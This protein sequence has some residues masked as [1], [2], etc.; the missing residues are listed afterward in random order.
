MDKLRKAKT[1]S[2]IVEVPWMPSKRR[3]AAL[4]DSKH[5][6]YGRRQCGYVTHFRH[7]YTYRTAAAEIPKKIH[8][9]NVI[10]DDSSIPPTCLESD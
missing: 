3:W 2:R 1:K 10:S 9:S 4:H 6:S 8:R 5:V 7:V